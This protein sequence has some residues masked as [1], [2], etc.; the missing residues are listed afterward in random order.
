MVSCRGD[1][2]VKPHSAPSV[3]KSPW[4]SVVRAQGRLTPDRRTTSGALAGA[5]T[6][7]RSTSGP[8][9]QGAAIDRPIAVGPA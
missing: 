9:V 7:R 1:V 4:P 3:G 8:I 5:W 2:P 6:R